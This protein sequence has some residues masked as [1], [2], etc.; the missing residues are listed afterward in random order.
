[1][2]PIG[3]KEAVEISQEAGK[4]YD[5]FKETPRLIMILVSWA[6]TVIFLLSTL[7]L[8]K[9]SREDNQEYQAQLR[10]KQLQI[11]V[12]R[13]KAEELAQETIRAQ[14]IALE[15]TTQMIYKTSSRYDTSKYYPR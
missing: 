9:I 6:F 1:M 12:A 5:R 7:W 11:D 10:L 14:K 8:I 15:L 2:A 13:D 4:W 3:T